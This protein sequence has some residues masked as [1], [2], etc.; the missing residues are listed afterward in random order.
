MSAD[1]P[2]VVDLAREADFSLG[3]IHV[4][5][6]TRQ[7]E[8]NGASET[9]EP[10]IMQVLVV[11]ARRRGEV[12]SRDDLTEMCWEGR[13][14]GDDALNRCISRIRKIGESSGGFRL[15]TIPRV[16]YRLHAE[17]GAPSAPATSGAVSAGPNPPAGRVR[18]HW[19][20]AALAAAAVFL[21]GT[22][23]WINLNSRTVDIAAAPLLIAVL[24]FDAPPD[25]PELQRF[26]GAVSQAIADGLTRSG[27]RLVP[28]ATSMALTGERKTAAAKELRAQLL[29]DGYVSREKD[30]VRIV[31]RLD[32][33]K[34]AFTVWSSTLGGALSEPN[35]AGQRLTAQIMSKLTLS[36]VVILL[37]SDDPL[38]VERA[39]TLL[40]TLQRSDDGDDRGAMEGTKRLVGI[41]ADAPHGYYMRT[42]ETMD[43]L[44]SLS[45]AE[46]KVE[47][48]AAKEAARRAIEIDNLRPQ[49]STGPLTAMAR[50]TPPYEWAQRIKGFEEAI[51]TGRTVPPTVGLAENFLQV[52]RVSDAFKW[53]GDRPLIGKTPLSVRAKIFLAMDDKTRADRDLTDGRDLWLQHPIFPELYFQSAAWL[54]SPGEAEERL[55]DTGAWSPSDTHRALLAVI[56]AAMLKKDRMQI[57]AVEAQCTSQARR[58]DE[59]ALLYCLSALAILGR[60]DAAFEVADALYPDIRPQPGEDPDARWLAAP[61]TAWD[62]VFLYM[63]WTASLRT[64]PR[65]IPV[66]ERLG[67]VDYWRTSGH[68]PDFCEAGAQPVCEKMKAA[69]PA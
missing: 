2:S 55:K 42:I 25:D 35:I 36:G 45:P 32:H 33:A 9:L 50:A 3:Q 47:F 13:V 57:S 30:R 4:R 65:I 40:T 12:V 66:F 52:G 17:E 46:R 28:A 49:E 27:Q 69:S 54:G 43:V 67:L 31:V 23:W 6:A 21:G 14:V 29:V 20:I 58:R 18:A 26:A 11:L 24:R 44:P 22:V 48:R 34:Q 38:S 68:W 41:W 8:S 51:A 10:R 63:P 1:T 53:M 61:A 19:V 60:N 37:N 62:P 64:D 16:G 5:P 15:E 39:R 59:A 56:N 7:V